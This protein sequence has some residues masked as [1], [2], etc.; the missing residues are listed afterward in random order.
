MLLLPTAAT[1]ALDWVFWFKYL[2]DISIKSGLVMAAAG[3]VTALMRRRYAAADRNFVWTFALLVAVL[4]AAGSAVLPAWNLALLPEPDLGGDG[5]EFSR[6]VQRMNHSYNG[7]DAAVSLDRLI[8]DL[9]ALV[10][11][12]GAAVWIKGVLVIWFGGSVLYLLWLAAGWLGLRRLVRRSCP[13]DNAWYERVRQIGREFGLDRRIRVVISRQIKTAIT[14]GIYRPVIILPAG[15]QD[16]ALPRRRMVLSHELAHIQRR[17]MFVETLVQAA[18]TL[19]WFH[20]LVWLGINRL[21]VERERACDDAVLNAGTRPSAYAAELMAVAA[22]L[23]NR[24]RSLWA[25]AVLSQGS[26]LKDR[27]LCILDPHIIRRSRVRLYA[28]TAG[29]LILGCTLP[30]AAFGLWYPESLFPPLKVLDVDPQKIPLYISNL[31]ADEAS[32]RQQAVLSLQ[33]VHWKYM[34]YV[35]KHALVHPD[36]NARQAAID[37]Q[38]NRDER[39]VKSLLAMA[40]KK[41]S[42]PVNR[43]AENEIKRISGRKTIHELVN[44]KGYALL[45]EGEFEKAIEVFLLN[46]Q[47]FPESSNAYDSL[48]EAYLLMGDRKTAARYY[49]MSLKLN[50]QN[51][52]A[53]KMLQMIES[54]VSLK[55]PPVKAG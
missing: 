41:A 20:P 9:R 28:A 36:E 53:A 17:D 49:Q 50:P 2:M 33:H 25:A 7:E 38:L 5:L 29:L 35:V 3:L 11:G 30:L 21:R 39:R 10:P 15:A 55:K 42:Y 40:A 32:A 8:D 24:R 19:Y 48:G 26:S 54:G 51:D 6:L 44:A 31:T 52:N 37:L 23:G 13:A 27:L 14:V 4:L 16:W 45:N 12:H 47:A 46:I 22:D 1:P 18:V 34:D 43:I